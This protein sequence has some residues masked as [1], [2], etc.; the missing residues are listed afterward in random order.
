MFVS[1]FQTHQKNFNDENIS[2]IETE[3]KRNRIVETCVCP[4]DIRRS[5]VLNVT[6]FFRFTG[7][8]IYCGTEQKTA[9]RRF[10]QFIS[11]MQECCICLSIVF[12]WK[13]RQTVE[14]QSHWTVDTTDFFFFFFTGAFVDDKCRQLSSSEMKEIF[15]FSQF[16]VI[17]LLYQ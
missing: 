13:V 11:H 15:W 8:G 9:K 7:I 17:A 1:C 3:I 16:F 2:V 4:Q 10:K 5:T 12:N 6:G 14:R